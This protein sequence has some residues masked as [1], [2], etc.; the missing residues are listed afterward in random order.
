MLASPA[1]RRFAAL[2]LFVVA[3][4]LVATVG[5]LASANASSD[6]LALAKPGWAPPAWLFGPVW[7][8]LYG[9]I[10]VSG[11]LVWRVRGWTP[12]LGVYAVQ[13]VLNAAWTPFFAAG[14]Y[15]LA[16]GGI[17]L[18]WLAIIVNVV[19][20]WRLRRSAALLLMPYLLWVSFAAALNAAIWQLN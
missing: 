17:V 16:F 6:Y 3:V 12:A 13:L 14:Q 5:S 11:W 20:F 7:T 15:G 18:L 19:A 1:I 8:L 2:P 10:A 4:A 9:M